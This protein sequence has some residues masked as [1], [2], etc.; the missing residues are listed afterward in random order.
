MY[1]P[2]CSISSSTNINPMIGR[3]YLIGSGLAFALFQF[4]NFF[5]LPKSFLFHD[6]GRFFD[7]ASKMAQTGEFWVNN[8]RQWEMPGTAMFF[9]PLAAQFPESPEFILAVRFL[10]SIILILTAL[11]GARLTQHLWKRPEISKC[12]FISFC[13]YPFFVYYQGLV[14]SET[15]YNFI[16]LSGFT[17]LYEWNKSKTQSIWWL[18]FA[19]IVLCISV[20]IKPNTTFLGPLL[21]FT[22]SFATKNGVKKSLGYSAISGLIYLIMLSPWWIRSYQ[23][24]G[25][26]VP[27]TT[28]ATMNSYLGNNPGNKTGGSDWEQDAEIWIKDFNQLSEIEYMNLY[29]REIKKFYREH[30]D[31]A[32]KLWW[33]KFKRFWNLTPNHP[34]FKK[35]IYFWASILSFGPALILF[36]LGTILFWRMVYRE[37]APIYL[38]IGYLT[39]VHIVTISSIRYRLPLEPFI[40][41]LAWG[42]LFKF[43]SKQKRS[44]EIKPES[45]LP[46]NI[47]P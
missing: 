25:Q 21:V 34:R 39:C 3:F 46:V 30:P 20:Y 43:T 24:F 15:L 26:V 1:T 5:I 40:L 18:V 29:G 8:Y 23:H 31:Q 14:L 47:H 45:C 28:G 38:Y 36:L 22:L 35:G 11:L 27:F 37:L 44:L 2:G 42:F 41:I 12:V 32:V 19:S 16:W 10:Q 7:S 13:F 4:Y 33:L 6:E 9:S 17:L